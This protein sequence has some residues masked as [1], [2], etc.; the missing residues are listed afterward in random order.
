MIFS[1]NI[2]KLKKNLYLLKIDQYFKE[3]IFK[4][5]FNINFRDLS[6]PSYISSLI[7]ENLKIYKNY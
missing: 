3:E 6:N 4:P 5:K 7:K 2:E 1:K